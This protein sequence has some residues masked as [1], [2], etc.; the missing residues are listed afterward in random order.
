[1]VF[2]SPPCPA[3]HAPGKIRGELS[4]QLCWEHGHDGHRL[5]QGEGNAVPKGASNP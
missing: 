5:Q 1:M 4:W 2:P 3:S